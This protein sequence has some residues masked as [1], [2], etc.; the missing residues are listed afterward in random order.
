MSAAFLAP[1]E[2]V[3]E[4]TGAVKANVQ[5]IRRRGALGRL[6][7]LAIGEVELVLARKVYAVVAV[8]I[9][10]W[11]HDAFNHVIGPGAERL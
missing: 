7:C 6:R 9:A 3:D 1:V 4:L 10:L 11:V 5:P 2:R 8:G